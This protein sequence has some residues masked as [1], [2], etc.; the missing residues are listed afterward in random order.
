ME[1]RQR[2]EEMTERFKTFGNHVRVRTRVNDMRT[3]GAGST[4]FTSTV[5]GGPSTQNTRVEEI[6]YRNPKKKGKRPPPYTLLLRAYMISHK[7]TFD[8]I[9]AIFTQPW[10]LYPQTLNPAPQ[11]SAP[12]TRK[13]EPQAPNPEP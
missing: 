5:M 9:P 7:S 12:A 3:T 8:E 2:K 6:V 4:S 10:T 1:A 11:K 13:A